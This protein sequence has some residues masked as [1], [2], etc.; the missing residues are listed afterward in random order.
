[1]LCL[2][3]TMRLRLL[4]GERLIGRLELIEFENVWRSPRFACH[5]PRLALK[6][7]YI[8]LILCELTFLI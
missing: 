3:Y 1:V 7:T 5:K 4:V 8:K 6:E 2:L